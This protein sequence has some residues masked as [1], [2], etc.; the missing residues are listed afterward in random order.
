MIGTLLRLMLRNKTNGSH[1]L[2]VYLS[3]LLG[4]EMLLLNSILYLKLRILKETKYCLKK[5]N[6]PIMCILS[7]MENLK[8]LKNE[9]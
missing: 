3:L 5:A 7:K 4:V 8:L 2:K 6:L 1:S 9:R